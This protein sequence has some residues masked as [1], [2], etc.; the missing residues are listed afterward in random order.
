MTDNSI[1]ISDPAFSRDN[2]VRPFAIEGMDV[3]GRA[4]RMGTT[5]HKILDAHKYPEPVARILG[6][7]LTL[8]ALLGSMMKFDGIV[9]IQTKSDGAVPM[10]V[11]DYE[12]TEGGKASLR[13]YASVDEDKLKQYGKNPSFHGLIGN[14]KGYMALT[15]DQGADMDRYQGIVDLKGETVAEVAREY[16]VNSEQTPTEIRLICGRDPVTGNWRSGGIMVQHLSRG[17]AGQERILERETEEEWNRAAIL[18]H[19]VKTEELVDPSLDLDQLLYR[20]FNEDGVRVFDPMRVEMGCRCSREKLEQVL[21]TL[22][23][24]DIDHATVDGKISVNC[25]FCNTTYDFAPDEVRALGK[26]ARS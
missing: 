16:F 20:L 18:M 14:K 10:L 5:V 15:I 26:E 7:V 2:E 9:T 3:R 13:G 11:A 25:Q 6:E 12:S 21:V 8:A 23:D 4:V 24:D 1:V 19:S 17:E 22:S